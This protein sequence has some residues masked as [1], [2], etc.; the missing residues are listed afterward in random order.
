MTAKAAV[1]L[2]SE[3]RGGEFRNGRQNTRTGKVGRAMRREE[4]GGG[5]AGKT[6]RDGGFYSRLY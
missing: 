3:A 2:C 5:C 4:G 6:A 1:A